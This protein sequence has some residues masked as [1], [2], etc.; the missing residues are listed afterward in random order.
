MALWEVHLLTL[1]AA[2]YVFYSLT[3]NHKSRSGSNMSPFFSEPGLD[4]SAGIG[5]RYA[6][7]V[8]KVIFTCGRIE[9]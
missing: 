2:W 4:I 8:E 5:G 1:A 3:A 9:I 6:M 7:N